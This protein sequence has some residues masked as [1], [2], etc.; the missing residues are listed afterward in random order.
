MLSLK[1]RLEKREKL[2]NLR[3]LPEESSL[4]DF[5]SND[6]LGLARSPVFAAAVRREWDK[7]GKQGYSYWGSTGSR[8]LTGNS[9][10]AQELEKQVAAFHGY[11]AGVLFNCGYMANIGLLST[12]AHRDSIVLFDENVHASTREGIRM[13]KAAA[14]PF[15]HN[16]MEHLEV[17]LKASPKHLEKLI[18]VES[19]YSTDGSLAPLHEVCGL[20]RKYGACVVVDEAHAIGVLGPQGKGLVA[21]NGLSGEVYAQV[22][23]FGKALGTCGAIVLGDPVLKQG[24]MNFASSYIYTT[25]LPFPVLASIKCSYELFPHME[26][27]RSHLKALSDMCQQSGVGSKGTPIH[28]IF[29]SGN[30]AIKSAAHRLAHAGFDVKPLMS[31][32]VQRGKELLRL[33]LHAFNT[34]QELK[35]ILRHIADNQYGIITG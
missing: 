17:R 8:L 2:G 12:L 9:A 5:A 21:E 34:K 23:T 10:Y 26:L 16:R 20:A 4:I 28:P 25:A 11:E 22:L 14:F 32:T 35:S 1:N 18:C 6:Y 7:C 15:R 31:P 19:V 3:R 13:S 24:L 30:E 29:I 27:E 33:C